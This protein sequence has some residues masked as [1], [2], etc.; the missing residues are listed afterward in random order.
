MVPIDYPHR[1]SVVCGKGTIIK[2][3]VS[4]AW[5]GEYGWG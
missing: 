5:V 2:T 3:R 1:D 4:L